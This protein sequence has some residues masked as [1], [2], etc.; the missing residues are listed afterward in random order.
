MPKDIRP[1]WSIITE[2]GNR[3]LNGEDHLWA[4]FI[5]GGDWDNYSFRLKVKL[6]KGTVHLNYRLSQVKGFS[7]YF[8]D[9]HT[10]GLYLSKQVGDHFTDLT[11][12]S[13]SYKLNV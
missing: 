12:V 4:R 9:F 2:D 3:V 10:G 6:I 13:T 1:P 8:I 7:R 5:A 11:E